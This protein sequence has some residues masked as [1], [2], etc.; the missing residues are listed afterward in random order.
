MGCKICSLSLTPLKSVL[1]SVISYTISA[2]AG[3]CSLIMLPVTETDTQWSKLWTAHLIMESHF[4]FCNSHKICNLVLYKC[5]FLRHWTW[6]DAIR[7]H[8]VAFHTGSVILDFHELQESVF[9]SKKT[10]VISPWRNKIYLNTFLSGSF[11]EF[12]VFPG[13]R[14]LPMWL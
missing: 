6:F 8:F 9:G 4:K 10:L 3:S 2:V 11:V 14:S 1:N 13:N 7:C 5:I 12:G